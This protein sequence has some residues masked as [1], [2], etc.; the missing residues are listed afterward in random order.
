MSAIYQQIAG[1][2]PDER[3]L[4]ELL[5][6]KEGI[7]AEQLPI[8]RRTTP[9]F[10]L[11]F[12]QERVW[13]IGQLSP[14]LPC[15]NVAAAF[16]LR[17]AIQ[18]VPF[19]RA[20]NAVAERHEMLRTTCAFRQ[21]TLVQTALPQRR[22]T[23]DVTDL[24]SLAE[25][26]RWTNAA[27]QA[28]ALAREPFDLLQEPLIR[29]A[30]WRTHDDEALL[31]LS[32]H[33]LLLDGW[34]VQILFRELSAFYSEF[35]SG[36]PA[37][38]AE[39]P[40]QYGDY[41]AWQR[42][43]FA[44]ELIE[45][46]L[47]YWKE[48]LRG[49]P[50]LLALPTNRPRPQVPS[51]RS[52]IAPV[53]FGPD[54]TASLR[55]IARSEGTTLFMTLLAAFQALLHKWSGQSDVIVG[56]AI[57]NRTRSETERLIGNFSNNL[58]LRTDFS[59][60]PTFRELLSRVRSTVTDAFAHQELPLELLMAELR[61]ESKQAVVPKFHLMF[62][63]R[64]EGT[65]R[66]LQL[67]GIDVE[68]VLIDTGVSRLDLNLDLKEC[69]DTIKGTL[70]YRT[71]LFDRSVISD[72]TAY[73]RELCKEV[74]ARPGL[75][76][77]DLPEPAFAT[78]PESVLA[79]TLCGQ[80]NGGALRELMV[81]PRDE[82]ERQLK[83]IW[84]GILG[85][86]PACV[87]QTFF[88][89]GGHSLLAVTLFSEI[90]R[91][92]GKK[93]PLATLFQAPTIEQLANVLRQRNDAVSWSCL[94]PI[95]PRGSKPPLFLIHAIGGNLL[96]YNDLV[97][98][99]D[100]EL[101]VYGLQS[102][103]LDG[104]TSPLTTVEEMAAQYIRDIRELLPAGPFH[105][106]G[107]SFGGVVAYEMARQ[108]QEEELS[109]GSVILLDSYHLHYSDPAS[110]GWTATVKSYRER[111][112]FHFENLLFKANRW[113]Y[114]QSRLAVATGRIR[115]II[116]NRAWEVAHS[117]YRLSG[118]PLPPALHRVND[119]N[120]YAFRSYIP[121]P[122]HGAIIL[123]RSTELSVAHSHDPA[124]AWRH[125]ALGGIEIHDVPGNHVTS[126]F[127]PHV[128]VV[129]EKLEACLVRAHKADPAR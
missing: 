114:L 60:S 55:E 128:R 7:N 36:Q 88:E 15:E 73:L 124:A 77:A 105:L 80:G 72:C 62:I 1:L 120:H 112:R 58:L 41:A 94:V 29:A 17:G 126:M 81:A 67:P 33:Q 69:G 44:R 38:L 106:A 24:R 96:N 4:F 32:V 37:A 27:A 46:Q 107:T 82:V 63:L 110:G 86:E 122:Y 39:L 20:L 92:F 68:S 13:T 22:Y 19:E 31:L 28:T 8:L 116:R 49:A 5:F 99:L 91:V 78:A 93:L 30:V 85:V 52:A 65:E 84:Q 25:H 54:I 66:S 42:D 43:V 75:R 125:L 56:T 59:A 6:K 11:S 14:D 104:K 101:P 123:F 9:E 64:D 48:Q 53:E 10:P 71:D 111:L 98:H 50:A 45:P 90:E 47:A 95:R 118:R 40:I 83:E 74:S 76:M 57:S 61:R 97:A 108:L 23:I 2:S 79:G 127:E 109:V 103:G 119:A 113:K 89:L 51:F 87:S 35:V 102:Q 100:P 34:S 115:R 12:S 117:Y 3:Q 18:I 26:E 21:G 70:T 16:R 121:K 129:A